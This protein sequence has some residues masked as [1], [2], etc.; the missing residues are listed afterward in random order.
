MAGGGVG[1]VGG[2]ITPSFLGSGAACG[3]KSASAQTI[4]M[5][6]F[7][8]SSDNIAA[9]A[10]AAASLAR[11]A[12]SASALADAAIRSASASALAASILR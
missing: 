3:A 1:G 8:R 4:P 12:A 5:A 2:G 10:A 9:A 6:G 7:A 11:C